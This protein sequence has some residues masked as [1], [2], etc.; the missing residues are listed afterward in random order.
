[1]TSAMSRQVA[2][3]EALSGRWSMPWTDVLVL[4]RLARGSGAARWF[5]VRS[6]EEHRLGLVG[7][8]LRRIDRHLP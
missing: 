4:E 6:P 8:V 7:R 2:E 3:H 5:L 1:M